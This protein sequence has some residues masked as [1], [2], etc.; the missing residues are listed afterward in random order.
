MFTELAFIHSGLNVPST[1][2]CQHTW[3]ATDLRDSILYNFTQK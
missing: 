1:N 3:E 2:F